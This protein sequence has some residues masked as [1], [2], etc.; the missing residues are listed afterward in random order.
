MRRMCVVF[1]PGHYLLRIVIVDGS[2]IAI[3]MLIGMTLIEHSI[4]S[5]ELDNE[6]EDAT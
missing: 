5:G 6:L 1:R 4:A 2:A 3:S